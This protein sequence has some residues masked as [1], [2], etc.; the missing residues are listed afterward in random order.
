MT[1]TDLTHVD[2][3]I[4]TH[5]LCWEPD[6]ICTTHAYAQTHAHTQ[7][8][9]CFHMLACGS[10]SWGSFIETS[11][12]LLFL[13][14]ATDSLSVR[15]RWKKYSNPPLFFSKST[16]M[17]N[18]LLQVDVLHSESRAGTEL[19]SAKCAKRIQT[20]SH[21]SA[22]KWPLW[23]KYYYIT[24][25]VVLHQ[26]ISSIIMLLLVKLELVLSFFSYRYVV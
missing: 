20:K 22:E 4:R 25:L 18:A 11:I 6:F 21:C 8:L 23:L 5:S 3:L 17:Q 12:C 7:W 24:L 2:S 10:M 19:E 1:K 9:K 14:Q 15:Q 13:L 16:T 26:F